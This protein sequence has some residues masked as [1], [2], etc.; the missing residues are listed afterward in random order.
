MINMKEIWKEIRNFEGLYEVSNIGR[1]K[2]VQRVVIRKNNV[3]CTIKEKIIKQWKNNK[4]YCC[5]NLCK[6]GKSYPC[7]VHR[8]VALAFVPNPNGYPEVMH[9]DENKDNNI[10]T[11]LIWGLHKDN[12]NYPLLKKIESELLSGINH[13]NYGKHL[14]DNTKYKIKS[15]MLNNTNGN[16]QVFYNGLIFDSAKNFAEFIG[17]APNT[18]RC[19]LN[20]NRPIP[21]R[22]ANDELRY[23]NN[24]DK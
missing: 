8:L 12:M 2:S 10:Y 7:T 13:P 1:V 20:G 19:W 21:K 18:D 9:D 4:G 23:I 17:V 14:L 3:P 6:N 24:A 16:K 15:K 11:N 22:F 5:V